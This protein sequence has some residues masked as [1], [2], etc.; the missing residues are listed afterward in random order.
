MET[1]LATATV[2]NNVVS[3]HAGSWGSGSLSLLKCTVSIYRLYD[4]AGDDLGLL[5]HPATEP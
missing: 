5:E 2:V 1:Q 3:T 4:T